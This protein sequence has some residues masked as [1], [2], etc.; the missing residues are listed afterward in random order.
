M[1]SKTGSWKSGGRSLRYDMI[2]TRLI[3]DDILKTLIMMAKTG[4]P[5]MKEFAAALGKVETGVNAAVGTGLGLARFMNSTSML[6]QMAGLFGFVFE[7]WNLTQVLSSILMPPAKVG[8]AAKVYV[9]SILVG[10]RGGGAVYEEPAKWGKPIPR[11]PPLPPPPPP[12]YEIPFAGSGE[13]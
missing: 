9:P 4:D 11:E 1:P 8:E 2:Y 5:K 6:G 3:A 12:S 10:A 13:P 7:L